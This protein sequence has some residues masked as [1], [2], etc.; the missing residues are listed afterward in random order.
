MFDEGN[1][2]REVCRDSSKN[3]NYI[4]YNMLCDLSHYY[5]KGEEFR[6]FITRTFVKFSHLIGMGYFVVG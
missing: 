2:A 4:L 6:F 1:S 3:N 5:K